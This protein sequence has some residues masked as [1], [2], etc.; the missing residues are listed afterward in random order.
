M[1]KDKNQEPDIRRPLPQPEPKPRPFSAPACSM[2]TA[3][4]PPDSNYSRCYGTI[5][6]DGGLVRYIR[7][8]F[9]GNSWTVTSRDSKAIEEKA[10]NPPANLKS[11]AEP[12]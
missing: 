7:C 5:P 12:G 3:V 4:R 8:H 1:P 2:C 11:E 10:D 6:R 9:C